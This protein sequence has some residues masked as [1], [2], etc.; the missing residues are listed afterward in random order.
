MAAPVTCKLDEDLN[1]F[2][3][4]IDRTRSYMG[5]FA[6][7]QQVTQKWIVR[8]GGNSNSSKILWLS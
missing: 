6:T 1:K 8:S 4:T 5:F 2:E 7:Q 3:G